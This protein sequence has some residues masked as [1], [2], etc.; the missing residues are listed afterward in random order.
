MSDIFISYASED[1]ARAMTLAEALARRNWTVWWDR[2]IPPGRSF[3]DVITEA[4]DQARC[5]V[6]LWSGRSVA[7]NWVKAEAGEGLQRGILVPAMIKPVRMPLEFRRI[8]AADLT[9]WQDTIPHAGFDALV[10]A[11]ATVL[12]DGVAAGQQNTSERPGQQ[13]TESGA[14]P[15]PRPHGWSAALVS[16]GW[17]F[18]TLAVQLSHDKHVVEFR[19][20]TAGTQFVKVDGITVAQAGGPIAWPGKYEFD[21]TDGA[22]RHPAAISSPQPILP[23][24]MRPCRLTVAGEVLYDE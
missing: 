7:S 13:P 10:N 3:D 24:K 21:L 20:A 4:L 17:T 11:V 5:V 16:T 19:I 18:R 1:R 6:V 15:R 2:H 9:D 8:Q 12:G 23:L 22:L 14:K